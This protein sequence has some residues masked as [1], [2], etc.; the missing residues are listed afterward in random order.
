LT[1]PASL[2]SR[3]RPGSRRPHPPP[4]T[5]GARRDT[6]IAGSAWRRGAKR[7]SSHVWASPPS[8]AALLF[9]QHLHA[10]EKPLSFQH[11]ARMRASARAWAGARLPETAVTLRY[12]CALVSWGREVG[13]ACGEGGAEVSQRFPANRRAH[14]LMGRRG[15]DPVRGRRRIGSPMWKSPY[16]HGAQRFPPANAHPI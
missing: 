8:G 6:A 1:P 14:T 10:R 3:H 9:S 4:P 13:A 15:S 12:A 7:C 16:S 2:W 11:W 5:P